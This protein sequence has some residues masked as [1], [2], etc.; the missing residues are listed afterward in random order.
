MNKDNFD[1]RLVQSFLT[2]YQDQGMLKWQGFYLSD[3]TSKLDRLK[4]QDIAIRKRKHSTEM[5]STE[6]V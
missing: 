1:P 6:I 3:H 2:E 4:A 5:T